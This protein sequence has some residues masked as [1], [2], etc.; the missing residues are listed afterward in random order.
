MANKAMRSLSDF[1]EGMVTEILLRLPVK[2]LLLCKSVCKP[3]LSTI[4]NPHFV[5][6]HIQH[7]I[8]TN[9][10]TLLNLINARELAF[11]FWEPFAY[12]LEPTPA[13]LQQQQ[14]QRRRRHLINQALND[15]DG[16][17]L[18]KLHL[19]FDRVD[20][21]GPFAM[22]RFM[23]CCNGVICLSN[24]NVVYLWNPSINKFKKVPFDYVYLWETGP[25]DFPVNVGF[26]YDSI[27]NE[28][29]LLR[30]VYKNREDVVPV[31]K[32][33]YINADSC[34]ELQGPVLKT[35]ITQWPSTISVN[36][37]LYFDG[38]DQLVSF[39]LH[40]EV[41][42]QVL[43]PNSIQRKRSDIMDFEGSVAMVFESGSGVDLWTLDNVAGEFSWTKKFS[44]EYGLDD[45]DTEI[46]LSCYL[47]AKQFYGKKL[48]NGNY[49][50]YE[51]LYDYVKKETKYYGL[52]EEYVNIYKTLEESEE[53]VP[54]I[55][56]HSVVPV[57]AVLKYT[58]TLVSLNGF[59]PVENAR[60]ELSRE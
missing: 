54:V 1:P 41:F 16:Q 29:K 44:I 14:R 53:Y 30:F 6:S 46:W 7:S 22:A 32:V 17:D 37:V 36:G 21:P 39:N 28:Y 43:F 48:L 56:E 33:Y 55:L 8:I 60:D 25:R 9:D 11:L 4:S 50:V 3:W 19:Q 38:E 34:R 59:E 20:I 40:D 26:G 31:V 45:L 35:K 42:G 57:H 18:S 2:S 13:E 49:F 52:R 24:Y 58:Q 27:S 23:T 51:I 10:P 5:K 15:A 12:A 47:G